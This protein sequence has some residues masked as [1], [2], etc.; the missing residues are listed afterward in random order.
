MTIRYP[1]G[2]RETKPRGRPR[3][4]EPGSSVST[5]LPASYHDRLIHMANQR[6]VKVSAL[7]RTLLIMRL[8]K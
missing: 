2:V 3:V 6:E 7:V 8:E 1:E 4:E 5:W